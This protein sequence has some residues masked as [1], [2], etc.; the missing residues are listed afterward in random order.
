MATAISDVG[1][2]G[3]HHDS[4][5]GRAGTGTV[6]R[7]QKGNL[8]RLVCGAFDASKLPTS[9]TEYTVTWTEQKLPKT[10]LLV[11]QHGA[12]PESSFVPAGSA[13]NQ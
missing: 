12:S 1:V 5:L 13:R 4:F 8:T 7:D 2:V 10:Q 11:C 3:L 9:G 6:D